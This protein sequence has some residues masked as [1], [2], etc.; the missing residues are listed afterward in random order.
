MSLLLLGY[1]LPN[2]GQIGFPLI[3]ST[4]RLL[5]RL[6]LLELLRIRR[7]Y[8]INEQTTHCADAGV[9][10]MRSIELLHIHFLATILCQ[11]ALGLVL[12]Q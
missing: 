7:I 11:L 9:Q 8:L 4:S 3:G 12:L 10:R 5:H 6:Q 1:K 2:A